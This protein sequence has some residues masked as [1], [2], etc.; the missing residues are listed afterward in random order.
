MSS[1]FPY[2]VSHLL[3]NFAVIRNHATTVMSQVEILSS[4]ARDFCRAAQHVVYTTESSIQRSEQPVFIVSLELPSSTIWNRKFNGNVFTHSNRFGILVAL[5]S[6]RPSENELAEV[7]YIFSQPSFHPTELQPS[8]HSSNSSHRPIRQ[9]SNHRSWKC[10]WV[11]SVQ[12]PEVP[13]LSLI[14]SFQDL[15]DQFSMF[16]PRVSLWHLWFL[17]IFLWIS[18]CSLSFALTL[19]P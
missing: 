1:F 4:F 18:P 5:T 16:Y 15:R 14:S 7:S 3:T 6:Q 11:M 2:R 12:I 10:Q 19:G 13:N 9:H 17:W 8:F